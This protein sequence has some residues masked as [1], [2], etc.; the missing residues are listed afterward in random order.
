MKNKV[1]YLNW[2]TGTETK[3]LFIDMQKHKAL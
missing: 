2:G 3:D 1:K